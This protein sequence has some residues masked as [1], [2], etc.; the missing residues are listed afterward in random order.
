MRKKRV[1]PGFGLSLGFTMLYMSLFVLIPLSIV[2]IQTSQLGWKKF[3]EV[4]TSE[5]VSHSYQVSLTTSLAAIVNA[6]FGLLIAWVLVR[7]TFPGKRLLDGLIDLPFALP[8]AVAG[9]TLTT[10]YA[11]NGWVGKIFS[12]F[13]IKVA[14]T[15]LG[16]IVALTF[17]GLPFVVR[18]VQPVLQNIDKEVEEAASSLGASRFQIFVKI[19]LPEIFPAL[20]AGFSLAFARAL[21]EYGSVIFIA[22][23]MPMKTEIAP[24]MIMT[25]LEQYDYAGATAVAAVMLI[26]SLLFLL[27]INMIQNWSR[28]HELKN[29]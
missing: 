4:V 27:L 3:A 11:E 23:N 8:T 13:H 28:R 6:I 5:R 19:I 7:Y 2:F 24:L 25:K 21:G 20:L 14:F 1:L 18:M 22:G 9:I 17:I 26:I 15:P 29:E 12:M 16:I 10:L